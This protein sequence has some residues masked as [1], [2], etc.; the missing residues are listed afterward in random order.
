MNLN[1]GHD[2]LKNPRGALVTPS[3]SQA[4]RDRMFLLIL[5]Q[6]I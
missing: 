3:P 2:V 1:V 6:F 5:G 4:L